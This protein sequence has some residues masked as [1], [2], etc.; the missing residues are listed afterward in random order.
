MWPLAR[1]STSTLT[2]K[3]RVI[4]DLWLADASSK[5]TANERQTTEATMGSQVCID[6][7]KTL[8]RRDG[9]GQRQHPDG[10][11]RD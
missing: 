8:G 1:R 5:P 7:E 11:R 3:R 2:K 6:D 10:S 4:V 9:H